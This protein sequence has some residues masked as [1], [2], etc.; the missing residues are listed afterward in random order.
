MPTK[1]YIGDVLHFKDDEIII[2]GIGKPKTLKLPE[3]VHRWLKE[4]YAAKRI[5]EELVTHYKFRAR[6]SH[7][8]SL[9]SLILLL[10]AR[11][12]GIPPYKVARKYG[13]APEQLY[14]MERGLK[15]DNLYDFTMNLLSLEATS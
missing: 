13:I 6:L 1:P 8:A 15:K 11:A 10:Y 3:E 14:R 12:H 5:L 7:P 4:S 9:R 2:Y